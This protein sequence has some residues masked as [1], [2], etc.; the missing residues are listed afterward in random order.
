MIILIYS[1]DAPTL[2]LDY[3][4][5]QLVGYAWYSQYIKIDSIITGDDYGLSL[6]VV[7]ESEK[8]HLPVHT[9]GVNRRGRSGV[10]PYTRVVGKYPD[11]DRFMINLA[12]ICYFCGEKTKPLAEYAQR[13]GKRAYQLAYT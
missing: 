3:R 8:Y 6:A 5:C 11:R 2:T 1:A 10:T 4:I 13:L 12:D 9:F 7:R